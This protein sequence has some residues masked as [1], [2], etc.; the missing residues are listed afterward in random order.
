MRGDGKDA[1][2]D[3]PPADLVL[4]ELLGLPA[5]A[6]LGTLLLMDEV[7]MWVSD[8]AKHPVTGDHFRKRWPKSRAVRSWCRCSRLTRRRMTRAG[9]SCWPAVRYFDADRG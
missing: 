8:R 2:R 1:E 9:V 7:M 5:K 4:E 3:T 6:G